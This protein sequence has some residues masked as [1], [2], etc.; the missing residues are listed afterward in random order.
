[1]ES[2]K[3]KPS[4]KSKPTGNPG[5]KASGSKA[6][7]KSKLGD[8]FFSR[9]S[10]NDTF[11]TKN[12]KAK[13]KA[14]KEAA[15]VSSRTNTKK[16]KSTVNPIRRN[17]SAAKSTAKSSIDR[18]KPRTPGSTKKSNPKVSIGRC[19]SQLTSASSKKSTPSNNSGI[20]KKLS[21]AKSNGSIS[22]KSTQAAA[23]VETTVEPRRLPAKASID[24][25]LKQGR[26]PSSI[27]Q[28]SL[29]GFTSD[30]L[31]D[32]VGKDDDDL[33]YNSTGAEED[34]LD[35]DFKSCYTPDEMRCMA[36]VA[37]NHMKAPMKMFVLA[38]KNLLRKFKLTGTN[39]TMTMLRDVFGDD[40]DVVYGPTCTSGPLGGD[41]ELVAV[42]CTENLGACVFF[43]DPM[44]THPH[45]AD[46]ECLTRQANVHNIIIMPNPSSAYAVMTTLRI[47]L[48]R[49][50]A[51]LIPS[52]FETLKSPSVAEYKKAQAQV[53]ASN[54]E[55][56]EEDE[57]EDDFLNDNLY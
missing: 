11:A 26:R 35:A 23:P 20:K 2:S 13:S 57:D 17:T 53:L 46:I 16:P 40:P 31:N 19:S 56:I 4:S 21:R 9:L 3:D 43:Q 54:A 52:F 47:A 34:D 8:S 38:N 25:K 48:E 36:L 1:M 18:N 37:H 12:A 5:A 45:A 41:A 44:S 22:T 42:M 29:L 6:G 32:L 50:K 49:G 28:S 39:T 27:L 7:T 55:T 30:D 14:R 24:T 15:A 10:N 33:S 51:E